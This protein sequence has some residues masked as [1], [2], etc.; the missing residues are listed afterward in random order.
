MVAATIAAVLPAERGGNHTTVGHGTSAAVEEP[1]RAVD[2][3]VNDV[4]TGVTGAVEMIKLVEDAVYNT[5][6]PELVLVTWLSGT[7][8]ESVSRKKGGNPV[9]E[10]C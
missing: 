8:E 3:F 5:R 2:T 1:S 9:G 6:G 7:V 4:G 10:G